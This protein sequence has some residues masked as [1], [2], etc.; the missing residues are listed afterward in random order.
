MRG[1]VE[2]PRDGL[3]VKST[4]VE[5]A[6]DQIGERCPPADERRTA[7][8]P[9]SS[10][11]PALLQRARCAFPRL[12]IDAQLALNRAAARDPQRPYKRRGSIVIEA[13]RSLL[14]KIGRRTW[15]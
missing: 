4:D 3:S 14:T 11:V 8:A 1:P 9:N 13:G 5:P 10:V 6:A 12:L 2:D 7:R 15:D